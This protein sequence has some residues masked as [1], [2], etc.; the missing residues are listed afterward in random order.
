MIRV[1]VGREADR[2]QPDLTARANVACPGVRE[3]ISSRGEGARLPGLTQHLVHLV[4]VLQGAPCAA[5]P[6][7]GGA[8]RLTGRWRWI[9]SRSS[10]EIAS[11]VH[12]RS[13]LPLRRKT[14]HGGLAVCASPTC[15]PAVPTKTVNETHSQLLLGPDARMPL[16]RRRK[17]WER[18]LQ[19]WERVSFAQKRRVVNDSHLRIPL[20]WHNIPLTHGMRASFT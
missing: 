12:R 17:S 4:A 15:R 16:F 8:Q 7:N 19:T 2:G 18:I 3:L 10:I 6:R 20:R 1:Y 5:S 13:D 9:N 14:F 11:R